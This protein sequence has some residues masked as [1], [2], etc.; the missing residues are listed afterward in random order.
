MTPV[1]RP[2]PAGG[3]R[4]HLDLVA[5]PGRGGRTVLARQ[6]FCAPFHLGKA[7]WDGRVLQV[8][9]VNATAGILAGDRLTLN[10]RVQ[11]GAAL[12]ATTPAATRAFRM[13]AGSAE[14]RQTFTVE[15]G[16]WLEYLPEPLC[17]H[18]DSEYLQQTRIEVAT[19]GE[20]CWVDTLAP[21]RVGRGEAWSWRR[22]RLGLEVVQDGELVLRE[23]F[24]GPGGDLARAAA[25]FGTPGGWLATVLILSPR[26]AADA[27]VWG[28]LR[29][30]HGGGRWLGATRLRRGGF[31]VRAVAPDGQ[32]LRDLLGDIRR[33]LAGSLPC[34]AGDLRKL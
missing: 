4:G 31:I 13:H 21:G 8:Q 17:P 6:D 2:A 1:A 16:G 26:L 5:A 18:R 32:A 24:D 27:A 15:A 11:G 29:A 28:R 3:L 10:V 14:C 34:L 30:L 9:V 19:G 25:F 22:L 20:V 33:L 7:Y 23:H 12:L